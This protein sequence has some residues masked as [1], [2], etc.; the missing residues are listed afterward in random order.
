[1]R[2]AYS[3]CA[4]HSEKDYPPILK[5]KVDIG[6]GKYAVVCWD[7]DGNQLETPESWRQFLIRPRLHVTH[8][9]VMGSAFGPVVR[10]TD[11][12]LRPNGTS[13]ERKSLF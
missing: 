6:A 3:S 7:E 2:A 12:L 10:L 4:R 13:M 1:M 8:L 11:A 5:T 9:W